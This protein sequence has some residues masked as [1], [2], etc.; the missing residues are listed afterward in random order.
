[1]NDDSPSTSP[2]R[3][4]ERFA[5]LGAAGSE[6]GSK[7]A[8]IRHDYGA[9]PDQFL[10]VYGDPGTASA[11]VVLVHGG[12]FRDRT[13][14]AHARPMAAALAEVGVLCVLIEYRRSGGQPDCSDDVTAAIEFACDS[15]SEWGVSDRARQDLIVTGHSAG[16]CLVLAWASH[17]GED[18]PEFRLRPLAPITDLFREVEDG[19]GEGAVLDYMGAPPEQ[20]LAPYLREDPRSRV[21]LIPARV[22]LLTLHGDRDQTVDIDFSRTFPAR[23]TVAEGADHAD[24][25]DPESPYFPLVLETL[26]S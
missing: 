22:D 11:T 9:E 14:L 12:Y 24:L 1:M 10:E 23:L 20:D 3:Q 4:D 13:D 18:G 6:L 8:A 19:L 2:T 26:L 16:G 21:L 25:V 5:A 15:L 7:R 17:L